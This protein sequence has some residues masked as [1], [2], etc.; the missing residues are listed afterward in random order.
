[1]EKESCILNQEFVNKFA[2]FLCQEVSENNTYKTKL[3]VVDCNSLFIIKGYTKNPK[4]YV[5]NNLTDK[6]IEENQDNYSDLTGLNLKTLDIIDY[7]TKDTNFEDTK[8]VFEYPETFATNKLSSITIQSTFPHG[9]SKNYLGNLYSYLYKISEK[10]QP[11]FKFRNIRL[12]F[13]SNEGNLKF[14]KVKSDSYYSS[15]LLLSILNDN[16]EGKVSD[17]YQLPSKLFLNVI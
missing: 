13:E 14:T 3:S 12:E 6:F 2:D 4:I 15:E 7:D 5:L 9:Y 11:Y 1:M 17:D 16:F 10:S 8:F